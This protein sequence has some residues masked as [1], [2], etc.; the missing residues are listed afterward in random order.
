MHCRSVS[1]LQVSDNHTNTSCQCHTILTCLIVNHR[2]NLGDEP[3]DVWNR[4][5]ALAKPLAK[6]Y[7][8][9]LH[10]FDGTKEEAQSIS[11]WPSETTLRTAPI[12]PTDATKNSPYRILA[13]TTR[14]LYGEDI[15]VSPGSTTGNTDTR[16]YWNLTKHIFRFGPGYDPTVKPGLGNIHTV[17]EHISIINHIGMVKWF[18]LFVRNMDEADL[19][20]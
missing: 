3:E 17:D 2:I 12:T 15:I 6:K 9:T 4:I 8:L 18:T 14:A 5:T 16:Y 1:L 19:E 7:N 13:A 11:L 20:D 10:A